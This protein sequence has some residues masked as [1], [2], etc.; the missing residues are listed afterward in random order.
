MVQLCTEEDDR[1]HK[2]GE[3]SRKSPP[4]SQM[5][6]R[7]HR[8][9]ST[10]EKWTDMDETRS[11]WFVCLFVCLL[12]PQFQF[13]FN[14]TKCQF[15]SQLWSHLKEKKRQITTWL[16]NKDFTASLNVLQSGSCHCSRAVNHSTHWFYFTA[17]IIYFP[18]NGIIIPNLTSRTTEESLK[19]DSIKYMIL[20]SIY[21]KL[22]VH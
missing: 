4:T 9:K 7:N 22:S 6:D 10:R 18:L 17:L 1:V 12:Q 11:R 8:V 5:D 16:S 14:R 3:R 21:T 2:T 19:C 15:L 13:L 20:Q